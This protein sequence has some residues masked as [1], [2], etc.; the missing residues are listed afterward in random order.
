MRTE[1]VLTRDLSFTI[2]RTI[3][4]CVLFKINDRITVGIPDIAV[5]HRGLTLWLEVKV[6]ERGVIRQH[7]YSKRQLYQAR[8]L[9]AQ[10]HCLYVIFDDH[11]VCLARPS[12]IDE[13]THR[14]VPLFQG[15]LSSIA[16]YIAGFFNQ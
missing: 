6:A 8:E 14:Y 9:E 10:G 13:I 16:N 4:Q 2:R 12:C 1:A 11:S 3:P 7:R 15:P 5:T